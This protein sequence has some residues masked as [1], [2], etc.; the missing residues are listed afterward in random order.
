M[1]Q[2]QNKLKVDGIV[3]SKTMASLDIATE[4]PNKDKTQK[5]NGSRNNRNSYNNVRITPAPTG[6]KTTQIIDNKG[7]GN[8]ANTV[9]ESSFSYNL[10]GT[11]AVTGGM[12]AG[13][14]AAKVVVSNPYIAATVILTIV[15]TILW[16]AEQVNV[17]ED[18][19]LAVES[20]DDYDDTYDDY[21]DTGRTERVG[22]QKGNAPRDNQKQNEQTDKIA[23][24]LGLTKEQSRQLHDYITGQGY[25]YNEILDI[26]KDL[27]GK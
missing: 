14:Q 3:G 27:F 15:F 9:Q 18:E 22:K 26:A 6:P 19:L 23:K 12:V 20:D 5:N 1:Y 24:E 11:I 10:D 25:S 17:G 8:F 7:T 21:Y 4:D 2:K 13:E 16:P